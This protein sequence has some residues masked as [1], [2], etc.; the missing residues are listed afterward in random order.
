MSRFF[1]WVRGF[2]L[3]GSGEGL[4]SAFMSSGGFKIATNHDLF[5]CS[6]GILCS[7]INASL[8]GYYIRAIQ[9][10]KTKHE[11]NV[12]ARFFVYIFQFALRLRKLHFRA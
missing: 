2:I 3:S 4:G 6:P 8:A 9:T 7:I 5:P 12:F 11:T 10:T 1:V